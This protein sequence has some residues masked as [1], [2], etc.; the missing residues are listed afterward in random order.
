LEVKTA[1]ASL[2]GNDHVSTHR[3]WKNPTWSPDGT[4]LAFTGSY[5]GTR[6]A[7]TGLYVANRDGT[8]V[9]RLTPTDSEGWAPAWS[10]DGRWIAYQRAAEGSYTFDL[11]VI[12]PDGTGL[13]R[14][15]RTPYRCH[16]PKDA[17]TVCTGTEGPPS[18]LP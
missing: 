7:F 11:Y 17:P 1:P 14:L 16:R 9:R 6:L 8:G 2:P 18:W 13:R 12:H 5:V 15:T 10:P 3:Q 4:R